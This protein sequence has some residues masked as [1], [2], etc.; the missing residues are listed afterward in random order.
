MFGD[1]SEMRGLRAKKRGMDSDEDDEGWWLYN[2]LFTTNIA[3]FHQRLVVQCRLNH[4]GTV[5]QSM[6]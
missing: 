1:S 4:V 6:Y 3:M 2:F 5:F